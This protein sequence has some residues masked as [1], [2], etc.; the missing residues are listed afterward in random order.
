MGR[1][2]AILFSAQSQYDGFLSHL[3]PWE[4]EEMACIH[5]YYTSVVD[6]VVESIKNDLVQTA[7]IAPGAMRKPHNTKPRVPAEMARLFEGE[8]LYDDGSSTREPAFP[9]MRDFEMLGMGGLCAF[10]T[11]AC[12]MA[13][14]TYDFFAA[15][16]S[17]FMYHFVTGDARHQRDAFQSVLF[18]MTDTLPEAINIAMA[19]TQGDDP[20]PDHL[21]EASVSARAA[22]GYFLCVRAAGL[23]HYRPIKLGLQRCPLRLRA[24]MFWDG[25]RILSPAVRRSLTEESRRRDVADYALRGNRPNRP[26]VENKLKGV[27]IP[28]AEMDKIYE[29]FGRHME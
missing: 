5:V 19:E 22:P 21:Y 1:G 28:N 10:S 12:F 11:D 24:Y 2:R 6:R 23:W 7:L 9:G 20:L 27:M 14:Q 16:G 15:Q 17:S 18:P 25:K 4:V 29:D 26:S 8:E 3:E 13:D